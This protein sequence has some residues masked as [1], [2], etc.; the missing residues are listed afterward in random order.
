MK[1]DNNLNSNV[2]L[3]KKSSDENETEKI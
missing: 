1:K 3:K 2:L